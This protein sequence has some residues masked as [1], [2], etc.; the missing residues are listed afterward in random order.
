MSRRLDAAP[1]HR[2]GTAAAAAGVALMSFGVVYPHFVDA[3]S[4]LVYLYASPFGLIPC[5]TLAFV[6][7]VT[8]MAGGFSSWFGGLIAAMSMMYGV[9]GVWR[10][11]VPLDWP[12]VA[13][14]VVLGGRALPARWRESASGAAQIAIQIALGP[15]LHRWRSRWGARPVE[16]A[17]EL[18]GDEIVAPSMWSYNHAITIHA[19]RRRVWPWLVQ[20]GQGRGGFYSYEGLE[21]LAGCDIH[22]VCE[23]RPELQELRVGDRIRMHASGVGPL[24]ARIDPERALVLGGPPDADGSQA[25]WAMYLFDEGDGRTRLLERGR[26]RAGRGLAAKLAFGPYL[27]DPIGFVMSRRMLQTIRRLAEESWTP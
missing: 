22:N 6:C 2:D 12:L 23:I 4:W 25:S 5:P 14:A 26:H 19:T 10:L 8:L 9:M 1:V 27:L 3:D 24:V 20:I 18:P 16:I 21:N 7:G 13:A 15:V 11:G 17:R